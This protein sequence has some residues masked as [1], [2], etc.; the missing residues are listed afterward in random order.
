MLFELLPDYFP[1]F[2]TDTE[3]GLWGKFYAEINQG[4]S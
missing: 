4:M 3:R 2:L 1:P